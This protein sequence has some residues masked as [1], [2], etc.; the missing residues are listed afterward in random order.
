MSW[1]GTTRE[2]ASVDDGTLPVAVEVAHLDFVNLAM[3]WSGISPVQ[4]LTLTSAV[5]LEDVTVDVVVLDA[6]GTPLTSSW[7]PVRRSTISSGWRGPGRR[8]PARWPRCTATYRRADSRRNLPSSYGPLID[9][10]RADAFAGNHPVS[11]A[12]TFSDRMERSVIERRQVGD[13]LGPPGRRLVTAK[14]LEADEGHGDAVDHDLEALVPAVVEL[15]AVGRGQEVDAKRRISELNDTTGPHEV[16]DGQAHRSEAEVFES[17][18]KP[19]R[20]LG[21]NKQPHTEI[22]RIAGMTVRCDR[23]AADDQESDLT[24]A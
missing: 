2:R 24:G 16:V 8:R 9:S 6:T 20:V 1:A 23:V 21:A 19:H 7:S 17:A 15:H 22:A 5:D 10:C 13:V 11:A 4:Q 3:A 18:K 14:I 12:A